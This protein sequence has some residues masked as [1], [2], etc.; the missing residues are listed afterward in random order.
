MAHFSASASQEWRQHWGVVFAGFT[1][2]ALATVH[3]YSIGL[4]VGPLEEEFG[5]SRSQIMFGFTLYTILSAMMTPFFGM[6]IDKFGPRRMGLTGVLSFSACLAALS[7]AT[8]SIWSWWLLWIVLS[9]GAV[10]IKPTVWTAAASSLFI[11]GRGVALAVVLCGTGIGSSVIPV[12]SHYLIAEFD[13]RIA[14]MSLAAL[15]LLFALP[16]VYRFFTSARDNSRRQQTA[17][18]DEPPPPMEGLPY[19]KAIFSFTFVKLAVAGFTITFVVTSF[20]ISLVP[21]MTSNTISRETAASI[22]GVVGIM[23][24]T[25][26]LMTGYLLDRWRGHI[27]GGMIFIVPII[28]CCCFLFAPDSIVIVTIGVVLLGMTLGAELDLVAYVATRHF[29]LLNFGVIFG[30]IVSILNAAAGSGPLVVNFIY[31]KTGSYD[32]ALWMYIPV[33]LIASLA[34]YS[35]G[36]YPD[37]FKT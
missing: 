17:T 37:L 22:A 8:P 9:C 11:K 27:L 2:M 21:I 36:D 4:F 34:I 20:V 14:Y 12:L 3:I 25:A 7:L 13:W 32:I 31:D 26:R 30:T 18:S 28:S 29:G 35:L 24:V 19:K 1:G 16:I 33:C 15:C 6:L 5:W 23:S 10:M